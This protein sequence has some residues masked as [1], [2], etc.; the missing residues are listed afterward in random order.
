MMCSTVI[1]RLGFECLPIGEESLRIISP[2]PYC[3]D[4]E[5][6]GA[7]VQHIN[8]GFKI[9]DRCDALM[10]IESRGI[11]LNQNRIE[12]IKHA[13]AKEGAELNERGE[14]TKWVQHESDL[15]KA[16]SDVIRAGILASALSLDWYSSTQAKKFEAEVVDFI[17]KSSVSNLMALR[18]EVSGMSGHN[19][20]IPVTIK[21]N[22]PKYIFT[23]SVK[24]GGSWNGA[25]SL[26]GKLMDLYQANNSI[27]NRYVVVDDESIGS[28]MQQLIL[29]FNDVS[30]VLPF[31]RR[32][33]WLPK[34]A[35]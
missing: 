23:S 6:V 34:L 27:N 9:S 14:I 3:D 1:S 12:I 11:A 25:Y 19:I 18:E 16:T 35:A 5:H 24:E 29:L 4:G 8:G 22:I 32:N 33:V 28:Q 10:N 26:L 13:L 31:E 15:G 21:T 30:Q 20:V 2:F 17:S 7:F